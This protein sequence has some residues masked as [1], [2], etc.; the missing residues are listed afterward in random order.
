MGEGGYRQINKT[1]NVCAFD[2]YLVTQHSRLPKLLDV[3]QLT[4]RVLRILGQ[5][6][7]KFTLQ[8]TNTYIVGTGQYR[9][10]IDTAQG[11]REWADLLDVTLSDRSI[12][13][14]HVLLTHWHGDHT[15]GVPDLI[16][17]YPD[18]ADGIYKNSPEHGQNPIEDGQIFKVEGATIRAV[19]G[20]G[21]S[22]DH[23]CFVLEEEDAMF[24]GDN[25]L[26]HGTSAVEQLG[27]YMET[28][29]KLQ[30]QGCKT[31]YPAHGAVIP[32]LNGRIAT[33]LAQKARR[34]NQCLTALGRIRK[35]GS[36]G[37]LV[38]VTVSEL[39]NVIHGPRLD[40]EVR[41]MALEPF[42][43][44]VLR[45]LAEDGKVAFRVRKGVKTWFALA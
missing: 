35:E 38:S 12:A 11:F 27:L 40:E 43:E 7:G 34:E 32:D 41:K 36:A 33:E 39:I 30:S 14:S 24:T 29:R 5:N 31:G 3:E 10:I 26:G 18:L 4:P 44:E 9:L 15:G 23:M 21:H 25:V 16:R 6:A 2:D 45:K 28:I 17:M 20:P 37:Q 19:H 8:G 42:M 22:E 1:L 13:L